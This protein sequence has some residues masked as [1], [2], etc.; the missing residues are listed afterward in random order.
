MGRN[1]AGPEILLSKIILDALEAVVGADDA[2]GNLGGAVRE[3]VQ[4]KGWTR[5][6][7]RWAGWALEGQICW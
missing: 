5:W 7:C 6:G 3:V 1:M 4:V 2:G